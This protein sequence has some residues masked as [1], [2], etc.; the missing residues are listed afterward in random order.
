MARTLYRIYLYFVVTQLLSFAAVVSSIFLGL[1]L[2]QVVNYHP[3]YGSQADL[4]Q[5]A[6]LAATALVFTAIFGGL[7]YWLIRRDIAHDPGA[8]RGAVRA[9]F[10]NYTEATSAIVA[11]IAGAIGFTQLGNTN[12]SSVSAFG[13][14]IAFGALFALLE[15]ERRRGQPDRG[16]ALILQRLN[17]YLVQ[18]ILLIITLVVALTTLGDT[19]GRIL[20]NTGYVQDPCTNYPTEYGSC[21]YT[22]G[23]YLGAE[24]LGVV[25]VVA[26][27]AVYGLL[28]RGDTHSVLRAVFRYI[29]LSVGIGYLLDGVAQGFHTLFQAL[30]GVTFPPYN[31][32]YSPGYYNNFEQYLETLARF[33]FIPLLVAGLAITLVYWLWLRSDA[34]HGGVMKPETN[35]QTSLA[36]F[37]VGAAGFFWV[38]LALTLGGIFERVVQS[39]NPPSADTWAAFLG[40]VAAGLIYI[41]MALWLGALARRTGVSVPRRAFVYYQLA[42]GTLGAV[43]SLIFLVYALVTNSLGA[44]SFD[45]QQQARQCVANVI[46]G[47]ILIGLYVFIARREG[48]FT[49]QP[50]H[51][52]PTSPA[53]QPTTI[54]GVLDELLARQISRDEAAARIR[55]LASSG[56]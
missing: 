27:W 47:A 40:I 2:Q 48:W 31:N 41:P 18:L 24:W 49:R 45:W 21:Y 20:I 8:S 55:A 7:H 17:H 5:P 26:I 36:L 19:V 37:G 51:A 1:W 29:G 35:F 39:G 30:F 44:P 43:I 32:P 4:R 42:Y 3:A 52:E 22:A 50:A 53:P 34:A 12:N 13:P 14:V 46:I 16:G 9:F 10:L 28:A 11:A 6:A 15:V 25:W 38:G 33:A 23:K 56:A 54:E